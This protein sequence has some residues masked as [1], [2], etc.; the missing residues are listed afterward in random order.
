MRTAV[1]EIAHLLGQRG[2]LTVVGQLGP[3][4]Y[5]GI[6]TDAHLD[7]RRTEVNQGKP[8][9]LFEVWLSDVYVPLFVFKVF[10]LFGHRH[11][12]LY[13]NGDGA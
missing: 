13:L 2:Q 1:K 12:D 3:E 9:T 10:A 11:L 7:D 5:I 8:A 4:A 6:G